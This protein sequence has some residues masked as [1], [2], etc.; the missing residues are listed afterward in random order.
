MIYGYGVAP[1]P[2]HQGEELLASIALGVTSGAVSAML[3]Y[4]KRRA[5]AF[6]VLIGAL[7]ID[8]VLMGVFERKYGGI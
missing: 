1:K 3:I 8:A 5:A 6:K 7:L 2:A 4:P